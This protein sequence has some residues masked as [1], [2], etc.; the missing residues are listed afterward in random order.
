MRYKI[1][2][3]MIRELIPFAL[4][5]WLI[6][7][8][9]SQHFRIF[10]SFYTNM[11]LL[12]LAILYFL[13]EK[14][15]SYTNIIRFMIVVLFVSVNTASGV[16]ILGLPFSRNSY[17]IFCISCVTLLVLQS[18]MEKRDFKKK[19]IYFMTFE[20]IV[21]LVCFVLVV[22]FQFSDLPGYYEH[23]VPYRYQEGHN[24]VYLTPYYTMG[25]YALHGLFSRNAGMFWEPGA[26]AVYLI[27]AILFVFNGALDEIKPKY[28]II[29]CGILL[30][31]ALSTKSTTGY[32]A[33]ALSFVFLV[34]RCPS[35]WN[36]RKNVIIVIGIV[37]GI[38][39][40]AFF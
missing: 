4:V 15:I 31:G 10:H 30:L 27:I 23:I 18:S 14:T 8:S 29:I 28:K 20:A 16:H 26:H 3:S 2:R 1:K 17:I 22:Y 11:F 12:A 35:K 34:L 13:R 33:L 7:C 25:W 36:T 21:S 9:G 40:V 37:L 19:Y 5:S 6:V 38:M 24:I 39:F 32:M